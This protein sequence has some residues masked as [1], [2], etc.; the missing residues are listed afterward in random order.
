[1]A[2]TEEQIENLCRMLQFTWYQHS[3]LHLAELLD[4]VAFE[5]GQP[6]RLRALDDAALAH[7]M[8]RVTAE[9]LIAKAKNLK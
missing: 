4:L 5:A 7:G 2:R 3:E 1:M 6:G 8:G 9:A